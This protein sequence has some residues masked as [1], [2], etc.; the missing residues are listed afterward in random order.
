MLCNN[1]RSTDENKERNI[2]SQP[3]L[4]ITKTTAYLCFEKGSEVMLIF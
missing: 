3:L 1:I 4:K 2:T